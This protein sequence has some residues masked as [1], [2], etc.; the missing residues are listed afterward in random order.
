MRHSYQYSDHLCFGTLDLYHNLNHC[1]E[2]TVLRPMVLVLVLG[3]VL[4]L[5]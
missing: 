3:L 5:D 1:L 2:V 4:G